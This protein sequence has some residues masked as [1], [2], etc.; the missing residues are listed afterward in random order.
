MAVQRSLG[1]DVVMAFDDCTEYPLDEA[2]TGESMERTLRWAKRSREAHAGNPGAL[3]GIVQ[4]GMYAPLRERSAK[5]LREIG[6]R[7]RSMNRDVVEAGDLELEQLRLASRSASRSTSGCGC[8]TPPCFCS[9]RNRVRYLMGVGTPEDI[10]EAVRRGVDLFDC[11]LPTR[12]ARNGYL[13]VNVLGRG[14][15]PQPA[16]PRRRAADRP[17]LRLSH[18]P[19]L[20]ARDLPPGPR[21]EIPLE[22]QHSSNT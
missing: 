11:V 7:L 6:V 16:L 14:Q 22:A 2:R 19:E 21:G 10:V 1:S 13:F 8:W 9:P 3:F 12:N 5:G 17:R 20:L 18:L 4:G 15:D